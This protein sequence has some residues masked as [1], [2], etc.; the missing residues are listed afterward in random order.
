MAR[1]SSARSSAAQPFSSAAYSSGSNATASSSNHRARRRQN[2]ANPGLKDLNDVYDYAVAQTSAAGSN[3]KGKSKDRSARRAT[4]GMNKGDL[5]DIPSKAKSTQRTRRKQGEDDDDE[6]EEDDSDE[7]AGPIGPKVFDSDDELNASIEGTDEDID[8]DEAFGDSDEEK[9]EGWTFGRSS[10]RKRA[11][12]SRRP[13]EEVEEDEDEEGEEDG[14]EDEGMMDLSRMLDSAS[15]SDDDDENSSDDDNDGTGSE[16]GNNS[17][18]LQKHMDSFAATATSSKRAADAGSGEEDDG[19]STKRSRR[20]LSE[21]TEAIP[22][23]EF[24]ASGSGSTLRLQD[25][26]DP[27]ASSVSFADIRKTAKVLGNKKGGNQTGHAPVASKQGGGALAAPLP[28]VV[29]DRL[30]RQAA[31]SVT[32]DEVQGWQPTI[33]KIRDAEHLSFPLQKPAVTKASTAGFVANFVPSNDMESS[34]AGMLEDGGLT[35]KQLA[36]QED[37]AM[38]RLDPAEVRARRDELRR[39]RMLMF[40]AEQKAKRV[41]K[42]KSKTY[43]KIHRK[44]QERIQAKIKELEGLEGVDVDSDEEMEQRLKAEKDR[45]RERATLKHKNTSKWAKNILSGRHGEH[46]LEAR[47]E[48]ESQL[49]KGEELRQKIQGHEIGHSDSD[50]DDEDEDDENVGSDGDDAELARQNAFD[51]LATLEAKEEKRRRKDEEEFERAGGKKGVYGMKF[52]KDAR[53]RDYARIRGEVDDFVTEMNEL[54]ANDDDDDDASQD[55]TGTATGA[56]AGAAA[57]VQGNKGRAMY[58]AGSITTTLAQEEDDKP[59]AATPSGKKASKTSNTQATAAPLEVGGN[60][61]VSKTTGPLSS[62]A[63]PKG[64][65]DKPA[66]ILSNGN[67]FATGDEAYDEATSNPW[68]TL[69]GGESGTKLSKKK[70]EAP[71]SRSSANAAKS[72][73]KLSKR[74]GKTAEATSA[75]RA[76]EE[77]AIDVSAQLGDFEGACDDSEVDEDGDALQPAAI[78]ARAKPR[79]GQMDG[80][81]QRELVEAAFAGDDVVAEFEA[82]KEAIMAEDESKTVDTTLPGWG[83]WTGK[84]VK[85][86]ST[87]NPKYLKKI[88]GVDRKD[89]KDAQLDRVIINEKRDKKMDKFR[90]RD[91]PHPYTSIAQYQAA[92]KNPLGPE[93]NTRIETQR[94][95]MPRITKKV[96]KVIQPIQRKF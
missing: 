67:P 39:M 85:A 82:E 46:T 26:L 88:Q 52:M 1:G 60:A 33:N 12:A 36:E 66:S 58:G 71:V 63:G 24:A 5:D 21:R 73:A 9:F 62:K 35:E 61:T 91:L 45:A 28:S 11:S 50:D 79:R 18:K 34:I 93:W 77:I 55:R 81:Q 4:A 83:S 16:D 59:A 49:R 43:R 69:G 72:S 8:S 27:L 29:Q 56:S 96:G 41:S 17:S 23:T 32:R 54:G 47:Q 15:G 53:E 51:E 74:A 68:L 80:F 95:N 84:G 76:D 25:F 44:E 65:A 30:D 89:R 86:R 38:N 57:Y 92:M 40:R 10:H 19:P 90:I 70:N 37:L 31:Y 94:L 2:G 3:G 42:I 20:V 13:Q 87:P 22:E 48:L 64:K 7:D 6:D 14:A 78:T 75:R